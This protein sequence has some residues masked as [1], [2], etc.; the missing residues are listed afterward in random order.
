[1]TAYHYSQKP[2]EPASPILIAVTVAAL[3]LSVYMYC[4][5]QNWQSDSFGT[6]PEN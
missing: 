1:M 3:A 4:S 2:S 6:F 5:E